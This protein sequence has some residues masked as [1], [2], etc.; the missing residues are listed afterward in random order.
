MIN[1]FE[2]MGFEK[3][4]FVSNSKYIR[5][6][7]IF[8][9]LNG[10]IK[11]L[12]KNQIE[13]LS[14]ILIDSKYKAP[15]NEKI[16]RIDNLEDNYLQ[17]IDDIYEINQS[18]FKNF[19][20]TGTNGKSTTI[21]FLS[22]VFSL[23]SRPNSTVGT[24]GT[25]LNGSKFFDN[26]LTT[27][28]PLFLR[29]VLRRCKDNNIRNL[30]IEASSIGIAQNRLKGLKIQHAALTNISRDHLD[31][32]K[33]FDS[34]LMSK[35]ELAQKNSL[36]TLTY[37]LDDKN[38]SSMNKIFTGKEIFSLSSLKKNAEIFFEIKE[39]YKDGTVSFSAKTPWGNYESNSKVYTKYNI[40]NLLISLPY[41]HAVNSNINEFFSA[42]E[43]INL[44]QGRLQ[45]ISDT[46]IFID[47]AHT[48]DALSSVCSELVI[49][50]NKRINL[51]FGAG[52]N[53]D[54][55][56]RKLMGK[57]AQKYANKIYLTSDNP[58]DENP[59]EIIDMIIEGI[60]DI[61]KV[62]IETDRAKAIKLAVNDLS[63]DEILLIA[64]KGH[65]NYQIVENRKQPFSDYEEILKCI[66]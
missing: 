29:S 58:R 25:Y 23:N 22:Q 55:G 54:K 26:N 7:D 46:N 2:N 45:K 31:Y 34:Y 44:P 66:K 5:E 57:I 41:Y 35:L 37:N 64:G 56:K 52:G 65:E 49:S 33:S 30:F 53:R 9:S 43:E 11:Y 8:I 32:H 48:P 3:R 4:N 21:D 13:K 12:K 50:K 10:G 63:N 62:T 6:D 20:V 14:L 19:F 1:P 28:E 40:Y 59:E 60:T 36:Q 15:I 24:L 61:D 17:W 51:L 18:T 47:F 16:L 39:I 38:F 42:V 27:E